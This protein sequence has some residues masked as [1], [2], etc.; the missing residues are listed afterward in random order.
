MVAGQEYLKE[1]EAEKFYLV[2]GNETHGESR[3]RGHGNETGYAVYTQQIWQYY[4]PHE[5]DYGSAYVG[6]GIL[7]LVALL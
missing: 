7:V 4:L 6:M 5:Y 3:A 2:N 1:V